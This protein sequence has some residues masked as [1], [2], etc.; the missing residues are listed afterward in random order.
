MDHRFYTNG[1]MPMHLMRC[2]HITM[3]VDGRRDINIGPYTTKFKYKK[4]FTY[5]FHVT[6]VIVIDQEFHHSYF[7]LNKCCSI[8]L[9]KYNFVTQMSNEGVGGLLI[10][11][12]F[13]KNI[14]KKT[15]PNIFSRLWELVSTSNNILYCS[16]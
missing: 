14:I 8:V 11:N 4:S 6:I 9:I 13:Q 16:L 10:K 2:K 1:P 7:S 15:F 5:K 12:F 3:S